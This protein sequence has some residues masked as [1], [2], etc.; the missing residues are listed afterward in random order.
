MRP[1]R[2]SVGLTMTVAAIAAWGLWV[3]LWYLRP[4]WQVVVAD[5]GWYIGAHAGLA[6]VTVA[7][8]VYVAA[9]SGARWMWLSERFVGGRDRIRSWQRR[10]RGTRWE[11]TANEGCTSA[12]RASVL[13]V[14][15]R[16]G[17][18]PVRAVAGPAAAG[19]RDT[20]H[21]GSLTTVHSN[22][23]PRSVLDWASCTEA[24]PTQIS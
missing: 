14:C 17:V 6:L 9:R 23:V 18:V 2:V 3:E 5:Y 15:A 16:R 19:A 8:G 10:W 11:T 12:G 7:A 24:S 13:E 22:T 4:F 1:W 20:G 21:G